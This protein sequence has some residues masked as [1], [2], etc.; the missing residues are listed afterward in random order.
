[1]LLNWNVGNSQRPKTDLL[2]MLTILKA[3]TLFLIFFIL[4]I[5]L[6]AQSFEG[7]FLGELL[8]ADNVL[9]I[10]KKGK[11]YLVTLT[12]N[13]DRFYLLDGYIVD[14]A[15]MF[16][17][18]SDSGNDIKIFCTQFEDKLVLSFEIEGVKYQTKFHPLRTSKHSS[19]S[20]RD[21]NSKYQ[22]DNRVFG[23]WIYLDALDSNG[24][25]YAKF[26]HR[27]Y[28]TNF[29][30]DG[31]MVFDPRIFA[32]ER[33]RVDPES[34]NKYAPS[35]KWRTDGQILTME[36]DQLE[37]VYYYEVKNDTLILDSR[38]GFIYLL[39]KQR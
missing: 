12:E 18:P 13:K 29:S 35:L 33:G 2:A 26:E 4:T 27:G 1:M 37:I 15:L 9:K 32:D 17:L 3:K 38:R 36:L 20:S 28:R 16:Q 5:D 25:A 11:N 10:E 14:K 31:S 24:K 21:K 6:D 23:T 34:I 39:K 30:S 19:L 7:S 8:S 22:N